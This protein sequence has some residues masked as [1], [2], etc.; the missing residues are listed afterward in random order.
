MSVVPL[1]CGFLPIEPL[2]PGQALWKRRLLSPTRRENLDK[3]ELPAHGIMWELPKML[4]PGTHPPAECDFIALRCGLSFGIFRGSEVTLV[5]THVWNSWAKIVMA[6]PFPFQ[7]PDGFRSE[8]VMP[9]WFLSRG[10][11]LMGDSERGSLAS[12]S[13]PGMDVK[14]GLLH[15]RDS[16]RG[17]G[18]GRQEM[19]ATWAT[20]DLVEPPSSPNQE[21]AL[22]L[23]SCSVTY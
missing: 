21:A 9:L 10:S 8:Q 22:T 11:K 3:A 6:I 7:W 17:A 13:W 15:S 1:S 23:N 20:E 14:H 4:I 5:W 19:T 16:R 18:R 12:W 2:P